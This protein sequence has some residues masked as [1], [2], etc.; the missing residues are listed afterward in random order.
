MSVFRKFSHCRSGSVGIEFAIVGLLM[1]LMSLAVIDFG[2]AL[3]VRNKISYASDIGARNLITNPATTD[4]ALAGS[5]RAAFGGPYPEQLQIAVTSQ[6]TGGV[7]YRNVTVVFPLALRAPGMTA[8][9]IDLTVTRRI[10][11]L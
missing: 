1:V 7:V 8:T 11:L 5:I 9:I 6:T 2:R 4:S 10:P 3:Y